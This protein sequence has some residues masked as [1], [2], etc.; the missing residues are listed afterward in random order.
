VG[1]HAAADRRY[2]GRS[3]QR[4]PLT[5]QAPLGLRSTTSKDPPEPLRGKRFLV[6]EDEPMIGRD[7]V[8]ALESAGVNIVGPI[9]SAEGALRSIEDGSFDG[10]L[11]DANLRGEPAAAALTRRKIPFVFATGYRRQALPESFGQSMMLTKPV[12]PEQLLRTAA[13]LVGSAVGLRLHKD[14]ESGS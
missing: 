12:T 14:L 1:D 4:S 13:Q 5:K 11:L 3:K 10:V 9:G 2:Y 8:A 7:I 6:V